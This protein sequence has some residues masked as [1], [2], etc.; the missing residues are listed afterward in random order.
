MREQAVVETKIRHLKVSD[1]LC[2]ESGSP[3]G[4][5]I[6]RMQ[7]EKRSCILVCREKRPVGIFTER[8]FLGKLLGKNMDF[9]RPVDD[10]MSRD[11]R[12]LTMDDTVGQ[13]IR[14]MHEH[15]YRNIPL[16]DQSGACAGLLQIRNVIEFLA[17]LYPE[18]VLNAPGRQR[19]ENT[20]GA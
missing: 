10:F 8:D 4:D 16:V 20:D 11:P 13:A 6:S 7:R 9:S 14:I 5:V 1:P 18:E 15:G 3:C 12:V 2:V 19:F 17:E